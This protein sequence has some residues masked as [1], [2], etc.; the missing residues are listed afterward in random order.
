MSRLG[1]YFKELAT[2]PMA[3]WIMCL[4]MLLFMFSIYMIIPELNQYITELGGPDKKWLIFGLWTIAAGISRPVSGKIADNISRKSVMY[5]GVIVS[6]TSFFLYPFFATVAGF[7][8]LRFIHGFSTG[9]QPTGASALIADVIPKGKRG[10]AMGIFGVTF[11]IG[12][13]LGQGIASTVKAAYDMDGLF[14]SGAILGIASLILL[15]F[16]AEDKSIVE[17]NAKEQGFNSL[18]QKVIPRV[19]EVIGLEV[20]QPAVVMFMTASLAGLYFL[21]IPD[22]S[23]H[24]GFTNKGYFWVVYAGFTILTRLVAGR[25]VDLYGARNNLFICCVLLIIASLVTGFAEG[26]VSFQVGAALYGLGSG[27]G[28]PAIFTWTADLSN[29]LYKGRGMGTMF[30]A[31]EFGILFGN[32]IGQQVY[33]N[34]PENFKLAFLVG[35]LLVLIALIFLILTRRTDRNKTELYL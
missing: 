14:M 33:Y 11:T 28:S 19:D 27:I 13:T 31:L 1:S 8:I 26:P 35:T 16:V 25:M 12:M 18:S 20:L 15:F 5:F 34:K 22:L 6:I 4:H 30:I 21:L 9:F 3:F 29:P 2:Y 23:E 24:I 32:F 17:K 7:L 10:Q